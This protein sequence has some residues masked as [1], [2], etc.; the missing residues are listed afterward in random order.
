MISASKMLSSTV[1]LSI[2]GATEATGFVPGEETVV[3]SLSD[4][5]A[6]GASDGAIR[7]DVA[8]SALVCVC[9]GVAKGD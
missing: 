5:S 1:S 2:F 4:D 3:A 8:V 7:V 9:D 6:G